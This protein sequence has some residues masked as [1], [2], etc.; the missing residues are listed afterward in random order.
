MNAAEDLAPFIYP[1]LRR[2]AG[3]HVRKEGGVQIQPTEL[4]HE[5]Y[6]RLMEQNHPHWESRYHFYS[7]AS[8]LMRQVLVDQARQLQAAKRGNG[9]VQVTLD[10]SSAFT[11]AHALDLLR[12][13]EAL[14][15]L[16]RIDPRK[17]R[18]IEQ[19]HFGGL[20]PD[21]IAE[22]WGASAVTIRR[23]LRIASAWL[24]RWFKH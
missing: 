20:K 22:L 21:E 11:D 18:V 17:A 19:H 6:L 4:V 5:V 9:G 16:E 14:S 8:R 12:L 10:Q 1:E 15:E 2:L 24:R 23:D 13:E 3:V 7:V